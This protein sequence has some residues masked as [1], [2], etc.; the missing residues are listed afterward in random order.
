MR[1]IPLKSKDDEKEPETKTISEAIDDN[2]CVEG[3][4][5][6]KLKVVVMTNLHGQGEQFFDN[7]ISLRNEIF[8]SKG[9]VN[10]QS[11]RQRLE[12]IAKIGAY[13]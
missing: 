5:E 7:F 6:L 13:C 1:F 11:L 9:W 8:E 12:H 3:A 10:Y 2:D 4:N